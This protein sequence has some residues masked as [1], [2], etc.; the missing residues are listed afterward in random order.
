MNRFIPKVVLV[1][2]S[3]FLVGGLS[4]DER[5]FSVHASVGTSAIFQT[6]EQLTEFKQNLLS[7]DFKRIVLYMD[8]GIGLRIDP[9]ISL[10]AGGIL[11][12][13]W[14]FQDEN[15]SCY[16][17]YDFYFGIRVNLNDTGFIVGVDYLFGNRND[18]Y[19]L[20][21]SFAEIPKVNTAWGN[22]F[23]L[24]TEYDFSNGNQGLAPCVGFSW[25]NI[26]RYESYDNQLNVY[27]K[28]SFR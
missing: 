21:E 18:I 2:I 26:P 22:G 8:T 14:Y 12:P 28:I 17:N 3:L 5:V 11:L 16:L 27:F 23:R 1:L 19:S 24:T 4:A 13:D 10:L 20:D 15:Y 6:D 7:N 25:L 9:N